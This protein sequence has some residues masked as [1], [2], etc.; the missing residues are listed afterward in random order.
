M[1]LTLNLIACLVLLISKQLSLALNIAVFALVLLYCLHSVAFLV[2][3]RSNP[4]L[5]AEIGVSLP[6]WLMMGAAVLS[7]LSMGV[8]IAVQVLQDV[9]TL[10]TQSLRERIAQHALTS[11]ELAVLWSTFA[12]LLYL[13]SKWMSGRARQRARESQ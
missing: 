1:S 5:Y 7:V 11:L 13:F 3:P 9:Q 8:L 10:M 6:R 2:L 4:K 12:A